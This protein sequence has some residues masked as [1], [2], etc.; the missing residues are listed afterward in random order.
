MEKALIVSIVYVSLLI[1][2]AFAQGEQI[3]G[4]IEDGVETMV[5]EF[6]KDLDF[7]DPNLLNA[8]KEETENLTDSGLEMIGSGIDLFKSSHHFAENLIQF[9]S[10]VH[11]DQFILFLVAGAIAIILGLSLLKRIAIHL[12]IFVVLSLVV[13]ALIIY[14]YY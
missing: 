9:L 6:T 5:N 13:V 8:T 3:E 7:S 12:L 10:P 14:F 1:P 4:F 2:S 11:V